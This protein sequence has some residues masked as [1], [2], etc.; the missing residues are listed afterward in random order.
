[1]GA[2]ALGAA[3]PLELLARAQLA[4]SHVGAGGKGAPTAM[5]DGHVGLGVGIEAPE[6]LPQGHDELVAEGVELL[7]TV[8]REGRDV[9]SARV[10]DEHGGVSFVR[11]F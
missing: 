4:L 10:L 8:E 2:E 6:R 5:D 9:V 7:G 1:V 11:G 3:Q